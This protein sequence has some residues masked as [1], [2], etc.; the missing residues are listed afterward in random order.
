MLNEVKHLVHEGERSLFLYPTQILRDAQDDRV[1]A[2]RW[3]IPRASSAD[4]RVW[5]KAYA[6]HSQPFRTQLLMP[7]KAA[8]S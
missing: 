2:R 4:R 3:P 6:L 1:I 7:D 5:R 8:Y